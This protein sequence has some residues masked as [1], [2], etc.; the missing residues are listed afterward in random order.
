MV[1]DTST[2][3]LRTTETSLAVVD[4][5]CELRGGTLSEISN[6]LGL[7]TSTVHTHLQTLNENEYV[8]RDG[9]RYLLGL[10]LFHLGERARHRDERYALAKR[11]ALELANDTN[12]EVN[13]SVEEHGRSIVLFD[14]TSNA[15]VEGY[16]VGRYFYMHNSA[17][18]KAM[19]AA[20]PDER[21]D[22][23]LDRWG[24]PRE[25]ENTV[26]DR[27]SLFAELERIRERG[28]AVND[29]EA[30]DGLRA[31]GVVVRDPDGGVLGALDISGPPY[32]LPDDEEAYRLLRTVVDDLETELEEK[33]A[34]RR[35]SDRPSGLQT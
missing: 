15:S 32:R 14:E 19:L 7:A 26:T 10:K 33:A 11:R 13:F 31:V 30:L 6:H 4:A 23:I 35:R 12:E 24:T 16:Q 21:V 34:L 22:H 17:S 29:Q 9:D 3:R 2:D 20:L 28:F 1:T 8:V 27:E 25:T 18:G 5:V